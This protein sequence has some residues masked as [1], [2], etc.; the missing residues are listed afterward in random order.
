MIKVYVVCCNDSVMGVCLGTEDQART[1]METL[2][3]ADYERS[4]HHWKGA[5]K[6]YQNCVKDAYDFY[7][8]ECIWHL[9][10]APIVV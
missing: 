8:K 10:G 3:R 6:Q 7:R 5:F 2:A 9:Q 4:R 1:A